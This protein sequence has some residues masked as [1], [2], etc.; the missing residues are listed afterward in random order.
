[1][2]LQTFKQQVDI[3]K[4]YFIGGGIGSLS[5]A[6][7]MIRDGGVAGRDITLFEKRLPYGG[8]LDGAR[9]ADGSYSMRGGRM[10]TTEQYECTWD[11]LSTIPSASQ[12][13]ENILS[14]TE[15]FNKLHVTH[16]QARLVDR[17]RHKVDVS[18]MGFSME[19]RIEMTR[20][21]ETPEDKLGNSLIS[22]WLSPPFFTTNFWLMWQTAFAFQPWHSAVEFRRYMRR[23][24]NEF[25]TMNTLGGVK[26][27]VYNQN[28]SIVKPLMRWLEEHGVNFVGGAD[29]TD[30]ALVTENGRHRATRLD[31]TQNGASRSIDLAPDD[32]VFYTAGSMTDATSLGSHDS[33]PKQLTKED[34]RGWALW[35]KLA[36]DRPEFGNPAIFNSNIPESSFE[37]FTVTCRNPRF[38]DA[39]QNFS[40][41][42]AGTGA[43]VSFTD[44]NWLMSIVLYTQPYFPDQPEGI[45]IFWGY[46]LYPDRVGNFVPKPMS[47]CSGAEILKELCGHLR[48]PLT[49]FDE[50]TCVPCWMPYIMSEF[51]PRSMGDRPLPVPANSQNL[52]FIGQFV[53][54]PEDA[55]FTIEYSVRGAMHAVYQLMKIDRAIP[56]VTPW[57]KS[58]K[59]LAQAAIKS[60]A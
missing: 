8:S 27:T 6:A 10:L 15:M 49:V 41:N 48:F 54:L 47:E 12:P 60:F 53:E 16:A 20:L 1:M 9:L 22:D 59:V 30:I 23:F 55:V 7:F 34:S 24:M 52:A 31:L 11:L 26:R 51:M 37:S 35:E 39:M 36:A 3:M 14:E 25:P 57:D 21:T 46:G 44:S 38:F 5:G 2:F 32:L 17:N 50:A 29:V 4:A 58:L 19:D 45:Q 33:P 18:T 42:V 43:L 28:D 56:P 13:S 40:G